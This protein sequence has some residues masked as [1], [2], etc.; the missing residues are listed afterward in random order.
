MHRERALQRLP[1]GE[2]RADVVTGVA[3]RVE[4]VGDVGLLV[5]VGF[6]ELDHAVAGGAQRG[7]HRRHR[8]LRGAAGFDRRLDGVARRHGLRERRLDALR[9]LGLAGLQHV[10][11][12]FHVGAEVHELHAPVDHDHVA[13]LHD[14]AARRGDDTLGA[15]DVHRRHVEF[16]SEAAFEQAVLQPPGG[17]FERGLPRC[18]HLVRQRPFGELDGDAGGFAERHDFRGDTPRAELR[19]QPFSADETRRVG[20]AQRLHELRVHRHAEAVGRA[21]L[22]RH[23]HADPLRIARLHHRREARRRP[24]RVVGAGLFHQIAAGPERQ[25]FDTIAPQV[26]DVVADAAHVAATHVFPQRIG[27][28]L[29]HRHDPHVDAGRLH[30]HRQHLF[31]LVEADLALHLPAP[32]CFLRIGAWGRE[33]CQR[34]ERRQGSSCGHRA[35]ERP[36]LAKVARRPAAGVRAAGPRAVAPVPAA[37]GDAP[38]TPSPPA[39]AAPSRRPRRPCRP[40]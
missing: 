15:R 39:P 7:V 22:V 35:S 26:E 28:V 36:T 5:G 12:A 2:R 10:G 20:L 11:D 18:D 37:R 4:A 17:V 23:V 6:V 25:A 19:H 1:G 31:E 24:E 16:G 8:L 38:P 30:R 21:D 27:V 33:Q 3:H 9:R 40:G 32:P 29:L 34:G 14:A 13:R